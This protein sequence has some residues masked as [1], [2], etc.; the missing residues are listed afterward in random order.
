MCTSNLTTQPWKIRKTSK[1][2]TREHLTSKPT[3]RRVMTS[4]SLST[5][6]NQPFGLVPTKQYFSDFHTSDFYS[7]I[8]KILC[9]KAFLNTYLSTLGINTTVSTCPVHGNDAAGKRS[10]LGKRREEV[11]FWKYTSTKRAAK[12]PILST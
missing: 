11:L 5:G 4:K 2:T 10:D 6:Q 7:K 9:F 8:S 3:T 1:S 12:A